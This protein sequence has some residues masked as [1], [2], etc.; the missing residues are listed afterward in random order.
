MDWDWLVLAVL[1][2]SVGDA[3]ALH[4]PGGRSRSLSIEHLGW[5]SIKAQACHQDSQPHLLS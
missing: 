5:H 2:D 4:E 3:K 1:V